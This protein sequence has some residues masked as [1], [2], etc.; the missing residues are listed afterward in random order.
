VMDIRSNI[1]LQTLKEDTG[2]PVS[3]VTKTGGHSATHNGR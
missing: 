2:V 1:V 3:L